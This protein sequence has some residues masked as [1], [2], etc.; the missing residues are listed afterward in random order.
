MLR[1]NKVKQA[2][3]R[4]EPVIGTMVS[5]SS[6]TG[7]IWTLANLGYDFVFI[8]MEHGAFTLPAVAEM[9][10]VARLAG[11]VPL[12]R[13]PDLAYHLVATVLDAG[14]MGL[15]LPRVET[16]AQVEQFVSFMKYPPLGVRGASAGRGHTDFTSAAPQE[17]VSHMNEHTL[18]ILQIERKRAVEDIDEL[19]AAPGVDAAVIGPFDLTIS[20]GEDS[21][22][23]AAVERAI[24][25]VV[26]SAARNGVASGIHVHDPAAVLNWHR[27]GMTL[28][29]CN[30]DLGFFSA[31]ARQTLGALRE[32]IGG[33]RPGDEPRAPGVHL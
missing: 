18:A 19:L 26:D 33:A 29:A 27:R 12:V 21:A 17:L 24:Q 32:G 15:M 30:S 28:L 25:A 10:K 16:R 20:L 22:G 7:F 14:A 2:L 6:A 31:G 3:K 1:P 23:A 8:D 13:V 9:I 4:G 11:T 5:E